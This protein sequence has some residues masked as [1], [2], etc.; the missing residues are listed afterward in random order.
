[1][2]GEVIERTVN[3]STQRVLRDKNLRPAIAPKVEITS[4]KDGGDLDF[5]MEFEVLPDVPAIDFGTIKLEKMV[6]KV[7]EKEIDE[8]IDRLLERNKTYTRAEKGA[9]AKKGNQ[10]VMDFV[11]KIDGVAFE[12]GTAKGMKLVL[13]S[14]QFIEGFEDQLI[15]AKEG[16]EVTVKVTFPDSYHK[17]DLAGKPAQFDV[18]VHEVLVGEK[19]EMT[20]EFVKKMGFTDAAGMRKAVSDQFAGD[21]ESAARA[22][23]KKELFDVLEKQ[24]KFEIPKSMSDLEFSSIWQKIEQAKKEGDETLKNKSD[25]DLRDEYRHIADRRVKLGILLS[26]VAMK[27]KIQINQDELSRAVM[28]QASQ[29]P[30]QERRIFEFYQQNPQHLEELRGPILE[31]KSVDFILSKTKITERKVSSEELMRET[32]AEDEAEE[33]P[34]KAAKKKKAANE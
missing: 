27:N 4:Y 25:D 7:E 28:N 11:G 33:T 2:L 32:E 6:C 22:H 17:Q 13:G 5:R 19:A 30:G 8:A 18:T 14:A 12:G 21:Y 10:L 34:K 23:M 20:D 31:E 3:Q 16:S 24:C 9:K 26:D 29:Y 1:V 15:G